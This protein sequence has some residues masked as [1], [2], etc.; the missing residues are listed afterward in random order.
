MGQCGSSSERPT[1]VRGDV[2]RWPI[3]VRGPR[4]Q[5]CEGEGEDSVDGRLGDLADARCRAGLMDT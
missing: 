2:E 1:R 3:A 4:S 5:H